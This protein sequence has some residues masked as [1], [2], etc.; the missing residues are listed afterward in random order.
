MEGDIKFEIGLTV[1]KNSGDSGWAITGNPKRDLTVKEFDSAYDFEEFIQ[2][3]INC[4]GVEFDSEFCQFFAY[5]KTNARAIK[6][7]KDI[8]KYFAKVR[9]MLE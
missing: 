8:E 7:A 2:T 3:R 1:Y 4:N 5:T 9:E 6:F